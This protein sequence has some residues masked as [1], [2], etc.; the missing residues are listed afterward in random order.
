MWVRARFAALE[1]VARIVGG[2]SLGSKIERPVRRSC[3]PME[4]RGFGF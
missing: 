3:D 2:V 4:F 1:V